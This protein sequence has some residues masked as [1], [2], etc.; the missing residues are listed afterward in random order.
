VNCWHCDRPAHAQCV[1]CGRLVCREHA[2]RLPHLL[3]L[4]QGRDGAFKALVV[5]DAI[6]CG[7]CQPRDE[8]VRL[9]GLE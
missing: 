3:S 5:P 9:E 8:P 7:I 2:G 4:Y 1:L 6:H